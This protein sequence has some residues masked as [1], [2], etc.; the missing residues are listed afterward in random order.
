MSAGISH[1]QG[2]KRDIPA[3]QL[4]APAEISH[5]LSPKRDIPADI[6]HHPPEYHTS[7]NPITQSHADWPT[8][9]RRHA[10]LFPSI[11]HGMTY[12]YPKELKPLKLSQKSKSE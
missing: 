10:V 7:L 5:K 2:S 4:L 6:G 3:E 1:K 9:V 11:S 8:C 12:G